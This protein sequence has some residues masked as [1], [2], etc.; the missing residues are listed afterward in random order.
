MLARHM[1]PQ[2]NLLDV[3]ILSEPA[4]LRQKSTTE[5]LIVENDLRFS[6]QN[7][8][9]ALPGVTFGSRD[10]MT[11]YDQEYRG[12]LDEKCQLICQL[13]FVN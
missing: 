11:G 6:M 7:C 9:R 12:W 10:K 13:I 8:A 4:H 5:S 2:T 3:P 1:D